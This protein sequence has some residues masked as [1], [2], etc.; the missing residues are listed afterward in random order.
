MS[1]EDGGS[2]AAAAR[3]ELRVVY[4]EGE[5]TIGVLA[6]DLS[7]VDRALRDLI[8]HTS[9]RADR[10]PRSGWPSLEESARIERATTNSPLEIVTVILLGVAGNLATDALRPGGW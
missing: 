8:R 10:G 5:P 9:G 6:A 1:I 2:D 7:L 3:I 4:A